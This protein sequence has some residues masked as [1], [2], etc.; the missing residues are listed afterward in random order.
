MEDLEQ[1]DF[2]K[3]IVLFS[4]TTKPLQG[5]QDIIAFIKERI[6]DDVKFE[7]F[8]TICRQVTNRIPNIKVFAPKH[9]FIYFV[10]GKKSS[11]GKVLFE[12]CRKANPNTIDRKSV[13]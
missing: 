5:F 2:T 11:N 6:A 3:G 1:L 4:Q 12:E 8:D 9:D 7:Y 10:A 13:V